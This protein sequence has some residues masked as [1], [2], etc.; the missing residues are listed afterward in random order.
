MRKRLITINFSIILLIISHLPTQAQEIIKS[1]ELNCQNI[2]QNALVS[3]PE[4]IKAVSVYCDFTE[5]I[6]NYQQR[7]K[8]VNTEL[9]WSKSYYLNGN[10]CRDSSTSTIC[11]TPES[12][13]KLGWK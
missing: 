4:G 13:A 5:N 1:S 10:I 11:L 8:P 2:S 12:A 7:R 6:S 3:T 9:S